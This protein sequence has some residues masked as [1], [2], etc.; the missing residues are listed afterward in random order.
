MDLTDFIEGIF[1]LSPRRFGTIAEIMIDRLFNLAPSNTLKY[2][3]KNNDERIEIKFSRALKKEEKLQNNNLIAICKNSSINNRMIRAEEASIS[4][5][6]CNI[7]Q[8]KPIEFDVLYYGIFFKDAIEIYRINSSNISLLKNYSAKQ[9]RGNE[10][11][12]QFHL[13]SSNIKEH[14]NKYLIKTLSY[15]QLYCLLG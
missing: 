15:E 8:I 9:H 3:R 12:G 6:D 13:N 11:E 1:L 14:R 10:G 2:D 5:F 7:Q 4:L